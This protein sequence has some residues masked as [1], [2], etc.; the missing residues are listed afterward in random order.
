MTDLEAWERQLQDNLAEL[1]RDSQ[2]LADKAATVRGR[3]E[4]RGVL[5]EVD[6]SGDITTLQIAPGAMQWTSKQLTTVLL[7]CHRKARADVKARIRRLVSK[8]DPRLRNQLQ[9][10]R[11]TSTTAEQ[12][13]HQRP[14]T[15]QEAQDADDEYFAKRNL[16]GGWTDG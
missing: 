14:M 1:R 2:Q 16:Y 5:V 7:D 9:H 8:A 4:V 11:S 6:A 3:G 15:A 13:R 10:I 12:K